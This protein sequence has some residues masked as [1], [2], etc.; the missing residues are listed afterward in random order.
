[1]TV[2]EQAA[3]SIGVSERSFGIGE[4]EFDEDDF[5]GEE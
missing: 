1:M 4:D 5:A 2:V 3:S